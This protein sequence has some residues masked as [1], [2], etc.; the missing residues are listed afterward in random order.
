MGVGEV[1]LR[2]D[3]SAE[4]RR[5]AEAHAAQLF[6][7]A[8]LLSGNWHEAEDLVQDTLAKLFVAWR[9]VRLAENVDAYVRRT[10]LN[11]FLAQ[12]RRKSSG[13]VPVDEF[14]DAS[15]VGVDSDLRMTLTSALRELPPKVRA[16]VV[17][18]Y[19]E[20]CSVETVAETLGLTPSGVKS[21]GMR[22]LARLRELLGA[23]RAHLFQN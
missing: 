23:E 7:L 6:R 16:V 17:L 15:A 19:V 12:R 5:F 20:D 8:Y 18:R 9:R 4:Y 1:G 22:G 21:A 13:E 3:D 11:T 2:A 10:L 14:H